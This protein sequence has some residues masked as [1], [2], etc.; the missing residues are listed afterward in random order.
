MPVVGAL[1]RIK[2][3]CRSVCC[4]HHRPRRGSPK[5]S[6]VR[7]D[8]EFALPDDLLAHMDLPDVLGQDM[9]ERLVDV[10]DDAVVV[11]GDMQI[12]FRDIRQPAAGEAS[13]GDHRE[14]V[15]L[16]PKGSPDDVFG[17]A[18]RR[19]RHHHIAGAGL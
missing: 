15:F 4:V 18:R 16:G 9:H 5:S 8:L 6:C 1:H 12:H 19:D 7:I 14:P 11:R 2:S 17:I 3:E 10:L 13:H